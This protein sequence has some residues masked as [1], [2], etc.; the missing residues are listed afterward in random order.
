MAPTSSAWRRSASP[1]PT[2]RSTSAKRD[3]RIARSGL[4][5]TLAAV[6]GPGPVPDRTLVRPDRLRKP[7]LVV[8]LAVVAVSTV[9]LR[10]AHGIV[11]LGFLVILFAENGICRAVVESL[12][13]AEAAALAAGRCRRGPGSPPVLEADRIVLMALLGSWMSERYGVGAI[14]LPLAIAQG[15]AAGRSVDPRE[16]ARVDT[17][18]RGEAA[19]SNESH[20]PMRHRTLVSQGRG[21]LG[22][23]GAMV[24][25]HAA[26]APGGVYLGFSSSAT[27]TPRTDARLRLR[28]QHGGLDARRLAGG[29]ARRPLGRKPLLIA[30]WTI[31]TVR[32]AWWPWSR[33]R[34]WPW[35]T[36]PSTAWATA[37][38]RCV[39]AAWV[40][41]RLADPRRSGEAAGHCRLVPGFRVGDRPG[42]GQLPG[43][44]ARLPRAVRR[45]GRR[46]CRRDGDRRVLGPGNVG[47]A[48]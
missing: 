33:V 12:S 30:G 40:T 13:G 46:R 25:Y 10:G 8:A 9:L 18:C 39:A 41:D 24:L 1:C 45:S 11:W 48:R 2:C 32:L 15:L 42:G 34:D 19:K 20:E 3:S 31:M 29:M 47:P 14:L 37:C 21:A 38:S 44:T 36:R 4:V 17:L 6:F 7:F 26:N 5:S 27:C 43:R 22:L 16:P 23:R 28:R 35:R